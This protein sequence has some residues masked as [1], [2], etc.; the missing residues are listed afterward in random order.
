MTKQV[1]TAAKRR[2]AHQPRRKE[3]LK[4]QDTADIIRNLLVEENCLKLR[5]AVMVAVG[6]AGFFRWNGLEQLKEGEITFRED[7]A[8]FHL[9]KR[10]IDQFRKGP[11]REARRRCMPGGVMCQADQGGLIKGDHLLADLVKT[12]GA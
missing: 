10:K 4:K 6:F 12:T 9:Q 7:N 5:T 2:L 11:Y 3:P 8:E 1:V